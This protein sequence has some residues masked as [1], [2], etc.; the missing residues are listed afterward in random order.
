MTQL[1]AKFG[2]FSRC[3][4]TTLCWKQD[5]SWSGVSELLDGLPRDGEGLE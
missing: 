2:F 1:F 5:S 4:C 3:L